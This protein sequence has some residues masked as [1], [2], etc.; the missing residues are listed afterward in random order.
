MKPIRLE[1]QA[2]GAYVGRQAF[3]FADLKGRSLFLIAGPTGS[4]KTT[5]LDAICF[6]LYGTTSGGER[7]PDGMRSDHVPQDVAT[8]VTFDFDLGGKS[9]RVRRNLAYQRPAKRGEG[10]TAEPQNSALWERTGVDDPADEGRVVARATAEV[11]KGGGAA[12][13]AHGR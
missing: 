1:M 7:K 10:T 4:G 12:G 2:F 6:A 9:Y 11:V 8:E 3:D 13:G 5:V